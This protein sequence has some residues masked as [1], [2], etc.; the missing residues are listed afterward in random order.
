MIGDLDRQDLGHVDDEAGPLQ[1]LLGLLPV[2]HDQPQDA[3]LVRVG[4]AER[5]DVDAGLGQG[6]A[7]GPQPAGLVLHEYRDLM[8]FHRRARLKETLEIHGGTRCS[9]PYYPLRLRWSITRRSLPSLRGK[10][11]GLGQRDRHVQADDPLD[12]LGEPGLQFLHGAD[13]VA[14]ESGR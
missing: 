8:D 3:V 7:R 10:R 5:E 6:L 14:E 9:P 13:A 2:G 1:D 4:Q 12:P 11:A